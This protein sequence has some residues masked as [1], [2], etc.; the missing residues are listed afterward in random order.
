MRKFRLKITAF[1][2]ISAMLFLTVYA[3]TFAE[4]LTGVSA[5]SYVLI[6]STSESILA[7][8]NEEEILPMASTTKIMTALIVIE[9]AKSASTLDESF[10]VKK[11]SIMVEGSSMGL[12]PNDTVTMRDLCYGMLLS[13]GNDAATAAAIKTSGSVEEFVKLMNERA[14]KIGM[15]NT[16]FTNPT[17]LHNEQHYSTAYDMARLTNEAMKNKLFAEICKTKKA[18]LTF[19]N[20]PYNRYIENHNKLLNYYDGCVGVKTGFTKMAGRC[21]VSAVERDGAKLICVTLNAPN[22]WSDHTALYDYGVPLITADPIVP[23]VQGITARVVGDDTVS[24][25]KIKASKDIP[26]FVSAQERKRLTQ[27]ILLRQ[28]YYAPI[29][30]GDKLGEVQILLDG[31]VV[32]QAQ[33]VAAL[34]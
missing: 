24:E 22:D 17:G 32:G 25:V 29:K 11:S 10:T 18:K 23:N 12:L 9:N 34:S 19:G 31:R 5:Q 30:S 14:K 2:A 8:R 15:K 21:L 1:F 13:S 7:S 3:P 27:R 26:V 33:L 28:F 4:D 16:H 20:P 6:E